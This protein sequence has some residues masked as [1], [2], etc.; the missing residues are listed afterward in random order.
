[1]Y[2]DKDKQ[3]EG[4][5]Y[6]IKGGDMLYYKIGV[7]QSNVSARVASLRTGCLFKRVEAFSSY[8]ALDLERTIQE[9]FKDNKVQGEWYL[10]DK[11][12]LETLLGLFSGRE[13]II[14]ENEEERKRHDMKESGSIQH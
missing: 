13:V 4:H 7:T 10:F 2:K 8:N 14:F 5:V 6:V 9:A 11:L 1:M 3:R 12:Q